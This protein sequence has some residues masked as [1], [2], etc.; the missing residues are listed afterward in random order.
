M[1]SA[2]FTLL[3]FFNLLT[4]EI[5]FTSTGENNPIEIDLSLPS[6]FNFIIIEH[7]IVEYSFV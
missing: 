4:E 6:I 3:F 2:S 5:I 7:I 1:V